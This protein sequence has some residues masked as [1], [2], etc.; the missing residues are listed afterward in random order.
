M[1]KK[2]LV[3]LSLISIVIGVVLIDPIVSGI[4]SK[5]DY[6]CD[7]LVGGGIGVT[8]ALFSL[9]TFFASL[10]LLKMSDSVFHSWSRFAKW[11]IPVAAVLIFL[12]PTTSVGIMG[13]D[14]EIVTWLLAG[15]FF[16]VSLGIILVKSRQSKVSVQ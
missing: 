15:I 11:Y 10:L 13:F 4:C 7:D 6:S 1:S 9:V 8:L 2:R 12:S 5:G 3:I 14:K 16:I